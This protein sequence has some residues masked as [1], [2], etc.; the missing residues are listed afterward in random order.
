MEN[1]RKEEMI[2]I[3]PRSEFRKNRP[4]F[5]NLKNNGW[6]RGWEEDSEWGRRM[7]G[8]IDRVMVRY[9]ELNP[10]GQGVLIRPDFWSLIRGG[11]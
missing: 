7:Q 10:V 8:C 3:V 6:D 1:W 11:E 5:A 2:R 9:R 4:V